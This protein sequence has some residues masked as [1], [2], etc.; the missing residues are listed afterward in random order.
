MLCKDMLVGFITHYSRV[1]NI[2]YYKN[3]KYIGDKIYAD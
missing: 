1:Y 3:K 2:G